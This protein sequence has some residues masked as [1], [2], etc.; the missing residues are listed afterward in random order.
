MNIYPDKQGELLQGHSQCFLV[1]FY[2][3]PRLRGQFCNLLPSTGKCIPHACT[4]SGKMTGHLLRVEISSVL[5]IAVL[6]SQ[7]ISSTLE[8]MP[9]VY[10]FLGKLSG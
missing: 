3:G 1:F 8:Q 4:L 10:C 6:V 5:L 7:T 9:T 2:H